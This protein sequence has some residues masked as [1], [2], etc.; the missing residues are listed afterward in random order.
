MDHRTADL[1][2]QQLDDEREWKRDCRKICS[3]I[4]KEL[5]SWIGELQLKYLRSYLAG[6][7][8]KLDYQRK[9]SEITDSMKLLAGASLSRKA[10][11]NE[12]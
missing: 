3:G 6:Y 4:E 5:S 10:L 7:M 1:C 9:V 12:G 11:F 2:I 8:T